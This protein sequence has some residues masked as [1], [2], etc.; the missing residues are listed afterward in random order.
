[1]H[2]VQRRSPRTTRYEIPTTVEEAVALLARLGD[3]ARIVAGGSDLLLEL[4]R[5]ARPGVDALVDVTRIPGLAEI[6]SGRDGRVHL[7]PLVTH[8]QVV[9]SPLLVELA[10]PLAQACWEIGSP[11]LR[12][13]ATIAGN[14]ITA[15][16]ANDSITPLRALDGAVKLVS[17]RGE[18]TVELVDFYTGL[19]DTVMEPDEM[20]VD[21]SLAPMTPEMRGTFVKLGLRRAQAISVVH[22]AAVL[23]FDGD[24]VTSARLTLGSVAPVII[25]LPE[26]EQ[27]LV[28]RS[29]TAEL[30][31]EAAQLA[32]TIPTPIDDVRGTAEYRTD[33]IRVMMRRGLGVLASDTWRNRWPVDPVVL[34][35]NVPDG[36]YPTG[37]GFGASLDASATVDCTIN[38][39]AVAAA[40]AVGKTLLDWLR[41]DAGPASASTL[42]GT[43]EGCGEG[44]CGACTV[45]LDGMAVMSCLVPAAR[46]HRAEVI[47]IEGL[48]TE[49]ALHPL[50]R[51]FV[52]RAAVQCGFCIPGFIMAGAKLLDEVPLPRTDQVRTALSGNLCRCTGY[53]KIMDAVDQA[54]AEMA[55]AS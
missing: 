31:E 51:A 4:E 43:K 45:Y 29:L 1:M 36:K 37:V 54:A 48:E 40:G 16:P 13:R 24:E 32:A 42:T 10:L 27:L 53:Y 5:G 30:I 20:M 19:R 46:A 50:Q 8:N 22:L 49:A 33:E 6:T 17:I 7:G 2:E 25:D 34:W 15:S 12:N 3:S 21:I 26:V 55:G 11:Q 14:L 52:N 41:D 44:E 23:G 39:E 47:T 38:G 18:R 35:G 9:R 28:G